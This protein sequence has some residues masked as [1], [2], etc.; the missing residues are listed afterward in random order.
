[1]KKLPDSLGREMPWVPAIRRAGGQVYLV[2]GPVRDLLL[3]RKVTDL[4]L[5]VTKIGPA[6]LSELL[7]PF[8]SVNEVGKSFGIIKLSTGREV[9]DFALPRKEKSTGPGHRDFWVLGD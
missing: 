4:D 1:V 3:S 8:G 6:R 2:G 7:A 9:L 5:M